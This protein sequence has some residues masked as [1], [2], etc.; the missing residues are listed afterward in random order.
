MDSQKPEQ[1]HFSSRSQLSIQQRKFFSP[2]SFPFSPFPGC[3]NGRRVLMMVIVY[4][5]EQAEGEKEE[6]GDSDED[7]ELCQ[8]DRGEPYR[9][10]A[11]TNE[12][13]I[14]SSL[15]LSL[16]K[17]SAPINGRKLTL[18]FRSLP[19]QS[20]LSRLRFYHQSRLHD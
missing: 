11:I 3:D 6:G 16:T 19:R 20:R 8:S 14:N 9:V 18:S 2:S 17:T 10:P 5:K 15:S 4:E 7:E 13:S 1:Y 12:A